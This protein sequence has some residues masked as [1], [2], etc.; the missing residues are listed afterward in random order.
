[1]CGYGRFGRE[2]TEDLRAEGIEVTVVPGEDVPEG[3]AE[4]IERSHLDAV[5]GADAVVAATENDMTNLWLIEE[6]RRR[7]GEA[8]LVALQNRAANGSLFRALDVDFSMI[9]AE[10]IAH[11]VMA[12]LATPLL[13]RFLPGVPHEGDAWA[14]ATVDRLVACCGDRTPHLWHVTLDD[15]HAP[16]VTALLAGGELRLGDLFRDPRGRDHALEAV[17][18]LLLRDGETTLTPDDDQLLRSGDELLVASTP[19][20][21]RGLVRTLDDEATA[22]Y[23]VEG[24]HLPSSWIWRRLS[25]TGRENV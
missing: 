23:V 8:F 1:M 25:R 22:T 17:P 3:R 13:M 11:E 14:A 16:G 6:V 10:V 20:G 15:R 24:R 7:N 12:R 4:Q 2:L 21:Q 18:L 19:T 9:P 5:A